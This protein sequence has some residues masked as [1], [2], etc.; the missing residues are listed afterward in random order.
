MEERDKIKCRE[1]YYEWIEQYVHG[2]RG[3]IGYLKMW[4]HEN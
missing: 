3:R 2:E 1:V 4:G